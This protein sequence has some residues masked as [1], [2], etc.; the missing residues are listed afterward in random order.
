[1][2]VGQKV[3]KSCMVVAWWWLGGGLVTAASALRRDSVSLVILEF[4]TIADERILLV[5]RQILFIAPLSLDELRL[6]GRIG[7]LVWI[8]TT[9]RMLNSISS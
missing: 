3:A 8:S 7:S 4:A 5:M 1:M 6:A 9:V 2:G